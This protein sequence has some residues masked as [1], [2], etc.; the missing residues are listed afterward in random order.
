MHGVRKAKI[1]EEL[2]NFIEDFGFCTLFILT[3]N[4]FIYLF[5]YLFI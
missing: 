4:T 2:E 3:S 1:T 5:I